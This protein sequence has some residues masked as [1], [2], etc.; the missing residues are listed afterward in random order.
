MNK[1]AS[2]MR[3]TAS[4]ERIPVRIGRVFSAVTQNAKLLK[5][6]TRACLSVRLRVVAATRFMLLV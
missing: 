3:H 6:K 1:A 4:E 5:N 2:T